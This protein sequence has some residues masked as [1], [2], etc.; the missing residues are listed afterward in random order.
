MPGQELALT[1]ASGMR[2]TLLSGF[3]TVAPTRWRCSDIVKMRSQGL[4]TGRSSDLFGVPGRVGIVAAS[5]G[6]RIT[7]LTR[8]VVDSN[9]ST[10]QV[11]EDGPR[12]INGLLLRVGMGT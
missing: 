5:H 3:L 9:F 2:T 8:P 7:D 11:A 6:V 10:P 4:E 1:L 12:A